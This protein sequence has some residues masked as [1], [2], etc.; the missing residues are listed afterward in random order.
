MNTHSPFQS[1]SPTIYLSHSLHCAKRLLGLLNRNSSSSTYG[2]FD[3]NYWHYSIT[4]FSNGR[5]QEGALTLALLYLIDHPLNPYSGMEKIKEWSLEAIKFLDSIQ[6]NDGSFNEYYP[7]EH[8]FVTTA[9]VTFACSEALLLLDEYPPRCVDW[10]RKAAHFLMKREECEVINQNLGASA[11]L[12]NVY[13]LTGEDQFSHNAQKKLETSMRYQSPEG[14]FHE[15]GGPDIGYLSV[16]IYYLANYYAKTTDSQA[17][18]SLEKAVWFLSHFIHPDGSAGGEYGSRNTTYMVPHGIE[19][20]ARFSPYAGMLASQIRQALNSGAHIAPRDLDDRYLCNMLYTYLQAFTDAAPIQEKKES[21]GNFFQESG[22]IIEKNPSYT[23]ISNLKK[24]G[25]FKVFSSQ[26][27]IVSDCGFI[28][29]CADGKKIT[30][31]WLSST[32]E[33]EGTTFTVKGA[34]VAVPEESMTPLKTVLMRIALG[35]GRQYVSQKVKQVLRQRLITKHRFLP[36]TF[37]RIITLDKDIHIQ[38]SLQGDVTFT[39][40]HLVDHASL[41][42]IPSSRYYQHHELSTPPYL[43][44]NLAASFNEQ[45]RITIT[46]TILTSGDR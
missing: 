24:G 26:K 9:F 7:H 18:S 30:S 25:V 28:G 19:I 5:L 34:C 31:Q 16:A 37:N 1:P 22:L 10:L 41:L 38:D 33:K 21:K 40:L 42:Y 35:L 6:L 11:A 14:W 12:Y 27:L 4:D 36:I 29:V 2:C 20:C 13:L 32:Y 39:S 3:R 15:Y 44:E 17:R 43:T 46:R 8:A 23:F 45:N